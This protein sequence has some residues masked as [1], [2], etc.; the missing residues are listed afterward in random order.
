M[1]VQSF[2]IVQKIRGER[3]GEGEVNKLVLLATSAVSAGPVSSII[4]RLYRMVSPW[5]L[6]PSSWWNSGRGRDLILRRRADENLPCVFIIRVIMICRAKNTKQHVLDQKNHHNMILR[7]G[8]QN[9][10]FIR[11]LVV[12]ATTYNISQRS[13][14]EHMNAGL[15]FKLGQVVATRVADFATSCCVALNGS[16]GIWMGWFTVYRWNKKEHKDLE[17]LSRSGKTQNTGEWS[18]LRTQLAQWLRFATP[19]YNSVIPWLDG[20]RE[21]FTLLLLL[22]IFISSWVVN[23]RN[24]LYLHNL[25]II[26]GFAT[27]RTGLLCGSCSFSDKWK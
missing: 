7:M 1:V 19:I 15:E 20:L 23:L 22:L 14:S 16:L 13:D 12:Y 5:N 18:D 24:P 8:K 6:L 3:G 2:G 9:S 11:Q 27:K 17:T 21:L 26:G 10:I 4:D 25:H